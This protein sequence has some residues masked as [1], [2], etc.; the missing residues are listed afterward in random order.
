MPPTCTARGYTVYACRRCGRVEKANG[1]PALG[2]DFIDWTPV[3]GENAHAAICRREGCG[4]TARAECEMRFLPGDETDERAFCPVCGRLSEDERLELIE[5][6]RLE[7]VAGETALPGQPV[8]RRCVLPDGR[9]IIS[10]CFKAAGVIVRP[11]AR[12][13]LSLPADDESAPYD[14]TAIETAGEGIALNAAVNEEGRIVLEMDYAL[15]EN[16]TP[17]T[18]ADTLVITLKPRAATE[19]SVQS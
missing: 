19:A 5:D 15:D 12:V 18:A 17:E 13:T 16:E 10:V 6:V 8:L 9:A 1:T 4:E 2:H 11:G 3:E 14:W 7:A